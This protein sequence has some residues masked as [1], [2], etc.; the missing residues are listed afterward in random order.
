MPGRSNYLAMQLLTKDKITKYEHKWLIDGLIEWLI[1]W[2]VHNGFSVVCSYIMAMNTNNLCDESFTHHGKWLLFNSMWVMFQIR[3]TGIIVT[4][5][6]FWRNDNN[7]RFE[8]QQCAYVSSNNS[9]RVNMSLN[10][11]TL[12]GFRVNLTNTRYSEKQQIL[13]LL[14]LFW[15]TRPYPE[16]KIYNIQQSQLHHRCYGL[17]IVLNL[18][19]TTL[20]CYSPWCKLKYRSK[21][22]SIF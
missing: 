8:L 1:D 16:L 18:T 19:I 10:S 15:L 14:F 22:I 20:A 7:I 17:C 9:S 21:F 6:Y 13:T 4:I 5:S 11:D 3:Y 2:L 12:S